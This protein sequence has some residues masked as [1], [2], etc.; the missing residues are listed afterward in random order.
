[1]IAFDN[2]YLYVCYSWDG[3]EDDFCIMRVFPTEDAAKKYCRSRNKNECSDFTD[4]TRRYIS[5]EGDVNF[6]ETESDDFYYWYTSTPFRKGV[7]DDENY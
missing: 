1:M 3:Y 4:G 2:S 5:E 7:D 6:D